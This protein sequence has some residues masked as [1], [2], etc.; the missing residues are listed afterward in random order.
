MWYNDIDEIEA[1]TTCMSITT[2]RLIKFIK[3]LVVEYSRMLKVTDLG[4]PQIEQTIQK[5]WDIIK[6]EI[7]YGLGPVTKTNRRKI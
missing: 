4:D 5:Y 7:N 2:R 6:E 3:I 1:E